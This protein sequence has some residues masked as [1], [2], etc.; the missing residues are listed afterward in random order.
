[1]TTTRTPTTIEGIRPELT[2]SHWCGGRGI[3]RLDASQLQDPP[4]RLADPTLLQSPEPDEM[5]AYDAIMATEDP[6]LLRLWSYNPEAR[7]YEG[8]WTRL[9]L[10]IKRSTVMA[11][12][13]T[14]AGVPVMWNHMTWASPG[15][16]RVLSME[17]KGGQLL[18]E[19][20]LSGAQ[21]AA[22]GLSFDQL[23]AGIN[24]GLS[25]GLHLYDR[26]KRK[27]ATG[28]DAGS[29]DNPDDLTYGRVRIAEVSLT[30]TPMIAQAGLAGRSQETDP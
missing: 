21:L 30:A 3:V 25:V 29:F 1:M 12:L 26:P 17:A 2:L 8:R 18:G 10:S 7:R 20:Q 4:N 22:F 5:I 28:D 13:A 19:V 11:T 15:L 23:D 9:R 6:W 14:P 24:R 27:E 16:G